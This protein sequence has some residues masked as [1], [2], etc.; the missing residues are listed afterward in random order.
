MIIDFLK[1]VGWGYGSICMMV[2]CTTMV[3]GIWKR[4]QTKMEYPIL[5]VSQQGRKHGG[6]A[7]WLPAP[8]WYPI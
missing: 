3:Q 7:V 8:G 4:S 2:V 6:E 1:W 5:R